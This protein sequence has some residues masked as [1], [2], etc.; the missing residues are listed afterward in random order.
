VISKPAP[1]GETVHRIAHTEKFFTA[2]GATVR[3]GGTMAYY[4]ATQDHVQ[5]PPFESFRDA[6]SYYATRS[7]EG[8][9]NAAIRI[10]A[11]PT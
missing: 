11:A 5:I 10:Y 2:T 6:E 7:H 4:S 8:T 1:R 9:H 3:H